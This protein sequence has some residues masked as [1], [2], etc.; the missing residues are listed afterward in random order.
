MASS[1]EYEGLIKEMV[2]GAGTLKSDW[3]IKLDCLIRML[4]LQ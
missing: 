1:L 2:E 3:L 4:G